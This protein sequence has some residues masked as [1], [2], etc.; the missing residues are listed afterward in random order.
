MTG[1]TWIARRAG[2][3]QAS[4]ATATSVSTTLVNVN[5]S[6]GA[7]SN[8][9]LASNRVRATEAITPAMIPEITSSIRDAGI[10]DLEIYLLGTRL[11]MILDAEEGFSLEAKAAADRANPKVQEWEELMWKFKKPLPDAKPGEKWL[12]MERIF[13][14]RAQ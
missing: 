9:I 11:F 7:T 5:G 1:S 2:T 3:Q 14:L 8:S 12:A 13:N 10:E 6:L 4:A